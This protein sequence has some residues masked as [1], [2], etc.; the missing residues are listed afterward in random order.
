[1]NMLNHL[2]NFVEHSRRGGVEGGVFWIRKQWHRLFTP[3]ITGVNIF[4]RDWDLLI[5]L[6]GCQ[7]SWFDMIST[8]FDWVPNSLPPTVL[9]VGSNSGEWY[10]NTF[11]KVD[12]EIL[13]STAL[14]T[15]NPYA[16]KHVPKKSICLFEDFFRKGWHDDLDLI[17][18]HILTDAAVETGRTSEFDR[19]IV[20]YMQPHTPFFETGDERRRDIT[21]LGEMDHCWN[22]WYAVMRG[23]V[24]SDGLEKL[25]CSNLEYVC[26]E[27]DKLLNNFDAED[28]VITSDHTNLVG[29][30]GM[31]GHPGYVPLEK[32]RR[33]PWIKRTAE[34]H[35]TLNPDLKSIDTPTTDRVERLRALGYR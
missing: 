1:M 34:D 9:S 17:P 32:L 21:R 29:T 26:S 14:I 22:W 35:G 31:Y 5:I 4:N 11:E 33:V 25:Y 28:V 12:G 2:A 7:P 10:K 6:D 27:V 3:D 8:D 15:G 19:Y 13:D 23:E 30:N 18:A 20:H 16:E 24:S